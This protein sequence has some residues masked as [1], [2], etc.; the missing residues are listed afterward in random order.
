MA[1][2]PNLWGF[3]SPSRTSGGRIR[4]RH[5]AVIPPPRKRDFRIDQA[6]GHQSHQREQDEKRWRGPSNR[7][8]APLF[9]GFY[10]QARPDAEA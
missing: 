7:Q 5:A 2:P 1:P 6:V 9:L 3:V 10:P 8:V 4:I